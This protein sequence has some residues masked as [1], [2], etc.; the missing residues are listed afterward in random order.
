ML[1]TIFLLSAVFWGAAIW[2]ISDHWDDGDDDSDDDAVGTAGDDVLRTGGGNDSILAGAGD[3]LLDGGAGTDTLLGEDGDDIAFG[4][5]GDDTLRGGMGDDL[6]FGDDGDDEIYG[7]NGDDWVEG[8]DGDDLVNGGPGDDLLVGGSGADVLNGGNGDDLLVGGNRLDPALSEAQAVDLRDGDS[9]D[10][11]LGVAPSSPIT[12]VD[13]GEPD[14]LHGGFGNDT[15][16]LGAGDTGVGGGGADDFFVLLDQA[17]QGPAIISDFKDNSDQILIL[18]DDPNA[19]PVITIQNSGNDAIILA[20]GN[21]LAVVVGASGALSPGD[22][23]I[24]APFT[25]AI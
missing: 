8:G 13:D 25:T 17:P 22:I 19:N 14:E 23:I 4:G 5:D 21:V 7:D 20:D 15:L 12:I 9:L 2:T 1:T 16:I 6:L 3:D 11:V 10:D 18:P 24:A